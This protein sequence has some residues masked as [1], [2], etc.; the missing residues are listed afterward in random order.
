MTRISITGATGFIGSQLIKSL[1]TRE[2][3]EISALVYENENSEFDLGDARIVRGNL[4]DPPSLENFATPGCTVINLAYAANM[5]GPGNLEALRNLA[6]TCAKIGIRRF[7]HCSTAVV[8][9]R[10]RQTEIDEETPCRPADAYEITKF[11]METILREEYSDKY[12]VIIL[13]PTAVFGPGGQNLLKL[14]HS[15]VKGNR[16]VNYIK[17]CLY[18][19]RK[20]NLVCVENV[21]AALEFLVSYKKLQAGAEI[22]IVSDDDDEEFN[23]YRRLELCLMELFQKQDYRMPPIPI[24][25]IFLGFILRLAGRTNYNL[26]TVYSSKKL[27]DAGFRKKSCLRSGLNDFVAWYNNINFE[28]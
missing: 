8:A 10:A 23:N 4:M 5:S 26:L 12:E 17:S 18:N 14:A 20:M 2:D 1:E 27:L 19:K 9:G 13:R 11:T 22:F 28:I 25:L 15:I 24:P 16:F 21:I 6:D 7:I 3:V